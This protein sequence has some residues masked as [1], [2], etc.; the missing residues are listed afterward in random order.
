MAKSPFNDKLTSQIRDRFAHIESDPFSGKRIFLENA[1]GTL[2][3][4]SVVEGT[5][6]F[7]ALP[8]NAGRRNPASQAVDEAI[9]KGRRDAALFVG[10][11]S[12]H[13]I[14]E[15]RTTGM[16]FRIISTIGFNARKGNMISSNL[17]HPASFDATQVI[18]ERYGMQFRC[19]G[20]DP[21]TGVVPVKAVLQHVDKDTVSV[22]IIHASNILGSKNDIRTLAGEIRKINP[23]TFIVIDGAQPACHGKV[24]VE[25][26][27]VDAW[28]FVPYKMFSKIGTAFAWVSD[29]LAE[30]SHDKLLGKPRAVWDLGTRET[31]SYAGMSKVVEYY[32]SLGSH[33]PQSAD[34]RTQVDAAME[35]IEQH[36][37][38]MLQALL[39]GTQRARGL[40]DMKH[41]TV[42]GDKEDA[43]TQEAIVA[44]TVAGKDTT[45][46]VEY[47]QKT[48]IR[49]PNRVSDAYS[50]HTLS[51]LGIE[52]CLRVSLCHYNTLDEG[53]AFLQTAARLG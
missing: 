47:F 46:L 8:D 26:Y 22:N 9:A 44:C 17:D 40:L 1:G 34:P 10:A 49:L 3:L 29:R 28:V 37:A 5:E 38:A 50:K 12:G 13:I 4:K 6:T 43:K 7:T 16:I 42:L 48:G 51:A 39:H 21:R 32:Q 53:E 30:L 11:G 15:Q 31:A 25:S 19:A 52:A 20:L 41:V 24:D 45:A 35:A 2:R 14:S 27:G 23:K 33:I 18:A 36:E